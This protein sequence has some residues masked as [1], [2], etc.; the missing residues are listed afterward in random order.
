M[1]SLFHHKQV[2][3]N[4]RFLLIDGKIF[5]SIVSKLQNYVSKHLRKR[6]LNLAFNHLMDNPGRDFSENLKVPIKRI[7]EL[8][9]KGK[10]FKEL[11]EGAYARF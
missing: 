6:K 1:L 3:K 10:Q 7:I 11:L 8:K 2:R 5:H 9:I 4:I